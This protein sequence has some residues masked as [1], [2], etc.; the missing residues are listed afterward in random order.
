MLEARGRVFG[1][2]RAEAGERFLDAVLEEEVIDDAHLVDGLERRF[3]REDVEQVPVLGEQHGVRD[4][5]LGAEPVSALVDERRIFEVL[6]G[7]ALDGIDQEERR[8]EP[9]T[10]LREEIVAVPEPFAERGAV[11]V[12]DA[13]AVDV[14][15]NTCRAPSRA[16][17]FRKNST[18]CRQRHATRGKASA[19]GCC[20]RRKANTSASVP[21]CER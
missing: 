10:A 8:G 20:A 6:V 7:A 14:A 15:L 17:S 11:V 3:V 9:R 21:Y 13:V 1:L 19:A 4:A 18:L 5:R 16:V 2:D 12:E